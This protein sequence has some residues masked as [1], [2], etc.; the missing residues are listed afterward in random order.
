MSD[1]RKFRRADQRLAKC[2]CSDGGLLRPVTR[3]DVH[4]VNYHVINCWIWW[5]DVM[6]QSWVNSVC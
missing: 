2:A 3:P 6:S 1:E 4:Q 5:P